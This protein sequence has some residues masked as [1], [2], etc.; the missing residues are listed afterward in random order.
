MANP[1][2]FSEKIA[3]HTQKQA[4]ETAA[5]EAI[6]QEVNS[7]TR[8]PPRYQKQQHIAP[9]LGTY[10]G[11]SLP[12]VNQISQ[13]QGIDLQATLQHLDDMKQGRS[14]LV[15][16]R[17]DRNR[18]QIGPH[19]RNFPPDKRIDSSPYGSAYHLSPPPDTS[20][21]RVHSDPSL[22]MNAM[23]NANNKNY[24][25]PPVTPPSHRRIVEMVGENAGDGLQMNYWDSKKLGGPSRPKS[26]EVP[27]INIYPSQEH[28]GNNSSSPVIQMTANNTGSL[29]DLSV[30]HFPSPLPTPLDQDDPFNTGAAGNSPV[31]LSPTSPHHM[32]MGHQSPQSPNQRRRQTQGMPLPSPLV[33][34]QIGGP[35]SPSPLSQPFPVSPLYSPTHQ[36]S[37]NHHRQATKP[38]LPCYQ[39][40][41]ISSPTGS[42]THSPNAPSQSH[43]NQSPYTSPQ[44][45]NQPQQSPPL[46]PHV[47]VT[48]CD[49]L[50]SQA[51]MTQ[52][53]NTSVS[54]SNC[55]SPTS[56]HSAPSYS[57]AQSPGIT[58][59]NQTVNSTFSDAYYIQQQ[60]QQQTNALQHQFEQFNMSP[61]QVNSTTM[62]STVLTTNGLS[63]VSSNS[64]SSANSLVFSQHPGIALSYSQHNSQLIMSS[65]NNR[66]MN[67]QNSMSSPTSGSKIPDI[68]LTGADDMCRLPLDFA[69]DLGNAITG[70]SDSFDADF[71]TNDEAFKAGLDPLDFEEIQMLTDASLVADP[72][73]ED[74]FKLDRL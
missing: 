65:Q 47:H 60:Q 34:N 29:P 2:K 8:A 50:G 12:N 16:G 62:D 74:S 21:R 70:M 44:H 69:K 55:Q 36:R 10:R 30:L 67:Q 33:L 20:W 35:S 9:N 63:L 53:R 18:Q 19:R 45:S 24:A 52:Y 71:L 42:P 41:H 64:T 27:N 22:H 51:S 25:H 73:T 26:C 3:L 32:P 61:P 11:G 59:N 56:P 23:G 5:F 49:D 14:T 57:P 31:S 43:L 37:L 68:I 39:H 72:A 66:H 6:L 17:Q 46:V 15:H 7:A 1:R 54:D 38:S 28:D 48:N 13:S 4:E 40:N 58:P